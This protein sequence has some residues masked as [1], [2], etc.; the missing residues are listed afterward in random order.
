ME[1]SGTSEKVDSDPCFSTAAVLQHDLMGIGAAPDFSQCGRLIVSKLSS[2]RG[3]EPTP[4]F[5]DPVI[6]MLAL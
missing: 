4:L 5:P 1:F 3:S 6:S 2:A